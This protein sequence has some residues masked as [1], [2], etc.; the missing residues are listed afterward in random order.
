M[1]KQYFDAKAKHEAISNASYFVDTNSISL[2][3]QISCMGNH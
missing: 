1:M 2:F 3:R